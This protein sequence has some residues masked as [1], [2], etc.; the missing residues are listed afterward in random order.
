MM[1]SANIIGVANVAA[2]FAVAVVAIWAVLASLHANKKQIASS[3]IQLS[4]QIEESRRLATEERQYQS[5]PIIVPQK[6]ISQTTAYSYDMNTKQTE[7]EILYTSDHVINWAY[8]HSIRISLQNMGN[9]LAFNLH[10]V[11][12]G[13]G[14]TCHEQFVSWDNGPVEAN[15]SLDINLEHSTELRLLH[16]TSVDGKHSLYDRSLDSSEKPWTDRIAC[17][18]LT[19][20]DL[21]GKKYVS[22]YH[23]TLPHQWIHVATREIAGDGSFDLKELNDRKKQGLKLSAS[24]F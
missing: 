19:Y 2:Q 4:K 9:G 14:N 12:Y 5:R 11:L 20:H 8:S 7:G 18:T 23:Y 24:L 1:S 22:I 13:S 3:E 15:G 10:A 16:N 17:L 6:Q 21:F